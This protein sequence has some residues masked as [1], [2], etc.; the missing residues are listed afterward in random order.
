MGKRFGRARAAIRRAPDRLVGV[1]GARRAQAIRAAAAVLRD[2]AARHR[3]RLRIV[4]GAA[5]AILIGA[6]A[7]QSLRTQ[8]LEQQLV[9]EQMR[10][11]DLAEGLRRIQ[12][13]ALT[14][15]EIDALRSELVGADERVRALEAGATAVTQVIARASAS[16]AFM[17]G[18][19]GLRDPATK[20]LLRFAVANGEPIRMPDGRPQMTLVGKGP[21]FEFRF[22]GTAFVVNHEGVLLTNRHVALPWEDE[23]A[24]PA[25][26]QLGLEPVMLSMRGYLAGAPEPF[27][28]AVL[29]ASDTHDLALMRGDGAARTAP[30]LR[31]SG[32]P[33]SPGDAAVLLGYPAG[34]R[35]LLARAGEAFTKGLRKLPEVDD[36]VAA[37][38]LARAGLVKPL[39]SRGIVAQVTDEAIV[40]DAQTGAGGSGG[41]VLNLKGEVVAVNRSILTGFG[42]SNIG[43]PVRHAAE[44]MRALNVAAAEEAPATDR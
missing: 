44:L 15:G 7:Y 39:A 3:R 19:F 4:V 38:E 18:S 8:D 36:E 2:V 14:R 34:I 29:G 9:H 5:L 43:V 26:R 1:A 40:H 41:P 30:A 11:T 37:H 23:F 42:G 21:L 6:I 20:R 33:P 16:V 27:D 28:V 25:I 12:D 31:L 17:Q 24:L 13:Q 35:A 10:V 32:E 22:S